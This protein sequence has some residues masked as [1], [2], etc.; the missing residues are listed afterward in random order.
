MNMIREGTLDTILITSLDC[1]SNSDD[2]MYAVVEKQHRHPS[3]TQDPTE[4]M[5]HTIQKMIEGGEEKKDD[6]CVDTQPLETELS[7]KTSDDNLMARG[8]L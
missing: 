2:F 7:F 5:G 8:G 3:L 1:F 4:P 6:E